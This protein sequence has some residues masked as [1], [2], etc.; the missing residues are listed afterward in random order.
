[1]VGLFESTDYITPNHFQNAG[2]TIY[3]IGKT[4]SEF[5]GSELQHLIEGK[6]EGKAPAIDLDIEKNYQNELLKAIR[7]GVSESAEDIAEGGLAVALAENAMGTDG[8]VVRGNLSGATT[9]A[10]LSENQSP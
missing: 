2:D 5:A 10:S 8:L 9:K 6:Y 4:E 7:A 3:V 1:M